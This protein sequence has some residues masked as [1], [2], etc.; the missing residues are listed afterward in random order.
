M[1]FRHLRYFVAVA[2]ERHFSRAARR[3]GIEQS[4]LSRAIRALEQD[5]GVRL[6]ER[7]TRGSK[8]TSAGEILLRHA[9]TIVALTDRARLAAQAATEIRSES[10]RATGRSAFATTDASTEILDPDQ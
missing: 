10:L 1:E 9:R 8:L 4:P 5:L 2:E 7:S 6:F 3:V